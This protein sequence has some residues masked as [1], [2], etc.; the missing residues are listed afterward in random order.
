MEFLGTKLTKTSYILR[1]KDLQ[2]FC[3]IKK[4]HCFLDDFTSC[5]KT[6]ALDFLKPPILGFFSRKFH[7]FVLGLVVLIDV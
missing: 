1:F 5:L 7:G 4:S 2:N 6:K 3:I